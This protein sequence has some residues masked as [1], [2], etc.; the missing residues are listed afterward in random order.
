MK[1]LTVAALSFQVLDSQ[2]PNRIQT[3]KR[4][5]PNVNLQTQYRFQ[6]TRKKAKVAGIQLV[7]PTCDEAEAITGVLD[8]V[9]PSVCACCYEEDDPATSSTESNNVRWIQ[10]NRCDSWFHQ[11]CAEITESD[12]HASYTCRVC[13][14]EL[15]KTN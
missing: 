14:E 8:S 9:T 15:T 10:C 1:H 13:M 7:K 2:E 3:R 6:S 12:T 4:F 11:S 5:A